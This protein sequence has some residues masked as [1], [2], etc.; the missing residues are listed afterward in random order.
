LATIPQIQSALNVG[1][2]GSVRLKLDIPA[3]E[4]AQAMNL[5]AFGREKLL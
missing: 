3:T 4:I 5:A 2:D 1:G